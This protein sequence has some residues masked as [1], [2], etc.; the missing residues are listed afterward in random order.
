M[1]QE[2][3]Y[4]GT[5]EDVSGASISVA[6]A[7]ETTAGLTFITGVAY[8]I[9]QVGAFVRIPIGYVDLFGIVTQVGAGAVP[10]KI[11]AIEPHGHR[12]MTVELIGEGERDG[13][14]HR[15]L[16]Q[17]PAIGDAVHLV[18]VRDL[19]R[20]Y[21]QQDKRRYVRIGRLAS[22]E[23]IPAY[24]NVDK[25][26]TR[27]S[28]VVGATGSGKS[29]TVAS[30]MN[31]LSDASLYPSARIVIFDIHG[32]YANALCD[33]ENASRNH[34]T[35]F[36]VNANL[37]R[38]EQPLFVPY[39]AMTFDELMPLTFGDISNDAAVGA[40]TEK[41]LEFKKAAL[42]NLAAAKQSAAFNVTEADLTVDSPVPFSVRQLWLELCELVKGTHTVNDGQ[43]KATFAY[44]LD[45]DGKPRQP[46]DAEKVIPPKFRPMSQAAGQDKIFQSK[47]GISLT[48]NRQLDALASRLR[49]PRFDFL[50]RPGPWN[51]A[52][53]GVP[54]EDLDTLLKQ[55]LGGNQPIVILDLSGVPVSILNALIGS[56]LRIIYD[57]LFWSRNLSEGGRERPL[58]LVLEEAHLYLGKTSEGAA[59]TQAGTA[60]RRIV[61]EGRKYGIGAMIVSQRPSEVDDTIL[62]QCGTIFAMRMSNESDRGH[63]TGAVTD[64]LK[65]LLSNLP[66]LRTGEAVVVGEAVHLPMRALVEPPPPGRR[67]D[68]ADPLI[69]GGSF[70]ENP[71]EPGGNPGGWDHKRQ[72]DNASDYEEIVEV[73]RLQQPRPARRKP[74]V[75]QKK[76]RK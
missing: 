64:N 30:L 6:L 16:S 17:S 55:W 32:E 47:A 18:T 22:A 46:G 54:Q 69:F 19:A 49:D 48:I 70:D 2:P 56:L 74:P 3:T 25:L 1:P 41:I 58:L 67:P 39:W 63:V 5:V 11:A 62:S 35:V 51:P 42:V 15:G 73:W 21:G 7:K 52:S 75:P 60:V 50:F 37:E 43:T 8:R 57:A 4:L 20:I 53:N 14:F 26:V 31:M 61:K 45:K 29:T 27:H 68:S 40:L 28:A 71:S 76:K 33:L 44:E 65:G 24:V 66:I 23:S 12:W 72:W 59:A 34:A 38:G 13:L 36:R 10:D 9:G